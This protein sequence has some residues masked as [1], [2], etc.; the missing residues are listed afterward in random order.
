MSVLFKFLRV[1]GNTNAGVMSSKLALESNS[2][3]HFPVSQN[4]G[5]DLEINIFFVNISNL[6]YG[7]GR[8]LRNL[9]QY[10]PN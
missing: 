8:F 6:E 10:L 9:G 2:K 3:L 1:E 5:R 7:V 4:D